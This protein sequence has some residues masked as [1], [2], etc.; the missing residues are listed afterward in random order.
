MTQPLKILVVDDDH[1]SREGLAELLG[2][3]GHAVEACR[4]GIRALAVLG[5]EPY[6]VLLTDLVMP[7]MSGLE[8]IRTARS[9]NPQLRCFVMT[10]HAP[11]DEPDIQWIA[12]PI[13][14]DLLLA[15]LEN[16]VR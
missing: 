16:P 13:D 9:T 7:G 5:S 6:D 15:R 8:L 11:T 10:G 3:A 2:Q 4:A 1:N 12:K 14:F